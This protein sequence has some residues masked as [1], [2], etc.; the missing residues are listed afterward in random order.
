MQHTSPPSSP[1]SRG[2]INKFN[3]TANNTNRFFGLLRP[4]SAPKLLVLNGCSASPFVHPAGPAAHVAAINPTCW[5]ESDPEG[6]NIETVASANTLHRGVP[7]QSRAR[8]KRPDPFSPGM[9]QV[10]L[11]EL[12]ELLGQRLC[13]TWWFWMWRSIMEFWEDVLTCSIHFRS[14]DRTRFTR[15]RLYAFIKT[16]QVTIPG[17]SSFRSPSGCL[18]QISLKVFLRYHIHENETDNLKT[19]R[20]WPQ[21]LP[22]GGHKNS[23]IAYYRQGAPS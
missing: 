18:V 19:W 9:I 13:W 5:H 8:M 17:H 2:F 15:T 6:V 1:P 4:F 22:S 3:T 14:Q 21:L 16:S 12:F 10:F 11:K 20:L 23:W 7:D